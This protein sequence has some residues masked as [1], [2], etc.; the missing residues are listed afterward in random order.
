HM[1][2]CPTMADRPAAVPARHCLATAH[3]ATAPEPRDARPRDA[4]QAL[5]SAG[6]VELAA[7]RAV[8]EA[9]PLVAVVDEDPDVW[10][11]S[12]AHQHPLGRPAL[13]GHEGDL[14]RAFALPGAP[15]LLGIYL[16][17]QIL[18]GGLP[19]HSTLL[20]SR[21]PSHPCVSPA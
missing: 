14:D 13:A 10:I 15:P 2:H 12:H 1:R 8:E 16:D 4:R 9:L 19:R 6:S 21:P 5:R 17:A 3:Q 11:T 7:P 20:R 18:H